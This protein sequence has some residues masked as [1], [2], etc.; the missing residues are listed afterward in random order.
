MNLLPDWRAFIELLNGNGV[1]YLVVGAWALLGHSLV[2]RLT[3][4]FAA[5]QDVLGYTECWK[6]RA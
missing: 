2:T 1:D 6:N 4:Y 5:R 3:A